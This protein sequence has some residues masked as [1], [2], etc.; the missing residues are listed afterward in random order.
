MTDAGYDPTDPPKDGFEGAFYSLDG[1]RSL[2]WVDFA[3]T[4][5]E[6]GSREFPF[7]TMNEAHMLVIDGGAIAVRAGSTTE[8]PRL[9]K[10]TNIHTWGGTVRIGG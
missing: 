6:T 2:Q 8:T 10:K 9:D 4:G 7:N 3:A 1:W 5:A